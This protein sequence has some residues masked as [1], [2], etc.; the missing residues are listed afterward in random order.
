MRRGILLLLAAL[1]TLPALPAPAHGLS[2]DASRVLYGNAAPLRRG[3]IRIG[4]F[5]PFQYGALDRITL[6]SH[7]IF[8]LLLTP[9]L[10]LRYALVHEAWGATSLDVGYAQSF[11]QQV[12]DTY[13]GY[14]MASLIQSFYL[15]DRL[16]LGAR[17]AYVYTFTPSQD[18]L[19][20]SAYATLL[21][22]SRWLV[23]LMGIF[24]YRAGAGAWQDLSGRVIVSRRFPPFEVALGLSYGR[25]YEL[26][27]LLDTSDVPLY[28]IIDV[29]WEF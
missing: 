5:S 14:W 8:D 6:M 13:R 3:E 9:N 11:L 7:P 26:E 29:V 21:I 10:T 23:H 17:A 16:C 20:P 1:A 22:G 25:A 27:G 15:L 19:I 12:N 4:V 24:P 2:E 28:P 18:N